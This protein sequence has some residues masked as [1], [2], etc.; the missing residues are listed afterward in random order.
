MSD[1]RARALAAAVI[2]FVAT[3][4]TA[5]PV[6]IREGR[7][8]FNLSGGLTLEGVAQG[9]RDISPDR[10]TIWGPVAGTPHGSF[11]LA[12]N[13][14]AMAGLVQTPEAGLFRL[15]LTAWGLQVVERIDGGFECRVGDVRPPA[16][17]A[18]PPA[19][20]ASG[21]CDDGSVID[22]LVVYTQEARDDAGGIAA[23]EAV[24]DVMVEY[25]NIAY[26]N[27]L[28]DTQMNL[29]YAGQLGPGE[30]P[31]LGELADPADGVVDGV[32]ALRDAYG[33]DQV[34]LIY[35]GGGGVALGLWNLDPESEANAFCANGLNSSPFVLAHELGHNMGCCHALGDG[36]GCPP[37]GGLLF[38]YSNGHRFEGDSGELWHT[39]MA[40]SPGIRIEHFSNPD[41]S[42]DGQPTGIPE[43]EPDAADNVMT[44]NLSAFTVSNWRCN[45]GICAALDLPG[46][47]ED[48]TGNGVP[49]LC[50][51]ALGTSDDANGNGVPDECECLA[52]LD[53]DG[54]VGILDFLMLLDAWGTPGAD[55]DGDGDTGITD[56][57][58]LL[59]NWGPCS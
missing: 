41:I 38:P 55:L 15:R 2:C 20:P 11:V 25:N 47:A 30:D 29:V 22:L 4:T 40:Y 52:D 35:A 39:V 59:A 27:S 57:L 32:H 53:G 58:A 18:A 43:G 56:F 23:I 49:D 16:V 6:E 9:R 46:D 48:C 37:E 5:G 28:V 54:V 12:V 24:I 26:A 50:D 19:V 45:D 51:I 1:P 36:G 34:A 33:A 44:I 10:F 31:D 14:D 8:L 13:R 21:P 42:F 7:V 17:D 3:H